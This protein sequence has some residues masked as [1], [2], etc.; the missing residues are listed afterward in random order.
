MTDKRLT[1]KG[2]HYTEWEAHC[3]DEIYRTVGESFHPMNWNQ[4]SSWRVMADLCNQHANALAKAAAVLADHWPRQKS[5]AADFFLQR[6]ESFIGIMRAAAN[7]ATENASAATQVMTAH[8]DA[9]AKLNAIKRERDSLPAVVRGFNQLAYANQD[10]E[11]RAVMRHLDFVVAEAR[12]RMIAPLVRDDRWDV[13]PP[14]PAH[15]NGSSGSSRAGGGGGAP[16]GSARP[17]Q[18]ARHWPLFASPPS[19]EPDNSI[20]A[21]ADPILDGGPTPSTLTGPLKPAFA[22]QHQIIE[23]AAPAGFGVGAGG[24]IGAT[25]RT[26]TNGPPPLSSTAGIRATTGASRPPSGAQAG[27]PAMAAAPMAGVGRTNATAGVNPAGVLGNSYAARKLRTRDDGPWSVARGTPAVIQPEPD[28]Q[29]HDP[30]P[31]VIGG[32]S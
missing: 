12:E 17:F 8:S 9:Y 22:S 18:E 23:S 1:R 29:D 21:G 7:N 6:V 14:K 31:G 5:A 30:G 19:A 15:L 25:M 11:A 32:V 3:L 20:G 10:D 13:E 16:T 28:P 2:Q 27:V 24:L 4:I 26:A